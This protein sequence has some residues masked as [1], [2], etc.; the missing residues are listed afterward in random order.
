MSKSRKPGSSACKHPWVV[1]GMMMMFWS[2]RRTKSHPDPAKP[3][4]RTHVLL[5]HALQELKPALERAVP[6]SSVPVQANQTVGIGEQGRAWG[7]GSGEV[8]FLQAVQASCAC[9]HGT[10]T[11]SPGCRSLPAQSETM[12]LRRQWVNCNQPS[13]TTNPTAGCSP[14]VLERQPLHL[15]HPQR[16]PADDVAA[17]KRVFGEGFW[18]C[19]RPVCHAVVG[20]HNR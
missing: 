10:C 12:V 4:K 13:T 1:R 14:H 8:A 5:L 2:Q 7:F 17:L 6:P 20:G 15:L 16:R 11:G 19:G 3:C 18:V 9:T